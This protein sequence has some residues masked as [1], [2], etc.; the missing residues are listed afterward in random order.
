MGM[1]RNIFDGTLTEGDVGFDI[2]IS[3]GIGFHIFRW[4]DFVTYQSVGM[5]FTL[6]SR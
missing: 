3:N 2:W 6:I 4:N 1:N 5:F